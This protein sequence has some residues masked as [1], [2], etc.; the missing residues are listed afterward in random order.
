[1]KYIIELP[2]VRTVKVVVARHNV[3]RDDDNVTKAFREGANE[4]SFAVGEIATL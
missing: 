1:M 2:V 3:S 4:R